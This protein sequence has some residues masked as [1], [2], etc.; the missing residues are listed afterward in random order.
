MRM[1]VPKNGYRYFKYTVFNETIAN[2]TLQITPISGDPDLY[3]STL[4]KPD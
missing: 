3:V 4:Q 1:T 2:V